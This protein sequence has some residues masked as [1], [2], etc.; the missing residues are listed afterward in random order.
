MNPWCCEPCGGCHF[1]GP[2]CW[3]EGSGPC[4]TLFC[5]FS[6]PRCKFCG[7]LYDQV[8]ICPWHWL[9][10]GQKSPQVP[11]SEQMCLGGVLGI[12][13][14]FLAGVLLFV[15]LASAYFRRDGNQA[16]KACVNSMVFATGVSLL[17]LGPVGIAIM[18][19]VFCTSAIC[20]WFIPG[21]CD[22][23]Y[24]E[25]CSGRCFTNNWLFGRLPSEAKFGG[26]SSA[27]YSKIPDKGSME[28][29]AGMTGKAAPGKTQK[30]SA[31]NVQTKTA[32]A[33]A[34]SKASAGGGGGG[35]V[36]QAAQAAQEQ[37]EKEGGG[38]MAKCAIP[39]C[40]L[41][42]FLVVIGGMFYGVVV[43]GSSA[44]GAVNGATH[45][46]FGNVTAGIAPELGNKT[47]GIL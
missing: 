27:Q 45:G 23:C 5:F 16:I 24:C 18:C 46:G 30:V 12:V 42:C 9:K 11:N 19:C 38:G 28:L 33:A 3:S 36:A 34:Q 35:G 47:G 32:P 21:R 20:D 40:G 1:Y 14:K 25:P 22:E 2:P 41:V 17:W 10:S 44:Y 43:L 8:M 37:E 13:G 15:D 7:N 4:G 31:G 39:C 29:E 6:K 26:D